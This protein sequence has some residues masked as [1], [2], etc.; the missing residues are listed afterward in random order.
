VGATSCVAAL[1][2]STMIILRASQQMRKNHDVHALQT[3]VAQGT[4]HNS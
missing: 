4:K 3:Q 2:E 1:F